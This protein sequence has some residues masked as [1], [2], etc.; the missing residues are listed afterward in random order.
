MNTLAGVANKMSEMAQVLQ[1][2]QEERDQLVQ[3]VRQSRGPA[4]SA[5]PQGQQGG[6]QQELREGDGHGGQRNMINVKYVNK[7][8]SFAGK[9]GQFSRMA[10]P[11]HVGD[12]RSF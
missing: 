4:T 2:Q 3:V 7:V 8:G 6:E 1:R 10:I 5:Q 12:P 9:K 11:D